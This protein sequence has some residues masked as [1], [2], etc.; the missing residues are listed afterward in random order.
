[1]ICIFVVP[2]ERPEYIARILIVRCKFYAKHGVKAVWLVRN[3]ASKLYED[4]FV[5]RKGMKLLWDFFGIITGIN[6]N[7]IFAAIGVTYHMQ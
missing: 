3:I 6:D 5:K 4:I 2:P 1:M 7:I